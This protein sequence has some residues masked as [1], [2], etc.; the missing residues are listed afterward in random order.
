MV[1]FRQVA[2]FQPTVRHPW[3]VRIPSIGVDA[4]VIALGYPTG[5]SLPVPPLS[6]AYRVGWYTF[7]SVPGRSGNTVLVGHVDTYLGPAVFYNL[8]LLRPGNMIY[9]RLGNRG[10]ARYTVRS[11]RELAKSSFPTTQIFSGT[12][13]R[14]LWLIT[15]G[16]PFDYATHH[17]MDN[18]VVSASQ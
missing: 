17:Y 4:N 7:S 9:I 16:G 18:I 5:A 10:Y 14:R 15:C 3:I 2:L 11:I 1:L 12:R 6:A 13:A 8:Y